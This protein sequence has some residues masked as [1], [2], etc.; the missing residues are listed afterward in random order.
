MDEQDSGIGSSGR[1]TPLGTGQLYR[2]LVL[3]GP[4]L[5]V[6]W[7]RGPDGLTLGRFPLAGKPG[8]PGRLGKGANP[9]QRTGRCSAHIPILLGLT[10]PPLQMKVF[11]LPQL[12]YR[13]WANRVLMKGPP[14]RPLWGPPLRVKQEGGEK[15]EVPEGA[16]AAG[17]DGAL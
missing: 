13:Q 3:V 6:L 12:V 9:L 5:K 7:G 11:Q 2:S 8:H 15:A 1:E 10:V 14:W 4:P 16:W 17:Q